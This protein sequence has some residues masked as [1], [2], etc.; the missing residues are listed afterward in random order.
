MVIKKCVIRK[1]HWRRRGRMK[2]RGKEDRGGRS[3]ALEEE[4][5]QEGFDRWGN[6]AS[7]K[8]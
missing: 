5:S 6:Q 2:R 8:K 4:F 7:E 3:C 1:A